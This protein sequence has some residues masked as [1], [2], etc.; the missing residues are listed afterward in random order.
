MSNFVYISLPP[1]EYIEDANSIKDEKNF[2]FAMFNNSLTTAD[3]FLKRKN[4]QPRFLKGFW[5]NK[6]CSKI[7]FYDK[8]NNALLFGTGVDK[9]FSWDKKVQ[10]H[11]M[12]RALLNME[13]A[14]EKLRKGACVIHDD[15]TIH[16][17]SDRTMKE[18]T[19]E[20]TS[21]QTRFTAPY[22]QLSSSEGYPDM[23]PPPGLEYLNP[24][25]WEKTPEKHKQLLADPEK[26]QE[27]HS[28]FLK[29]INLYKA[30]IDD[31]PFIQKVPEEQELLNNSTKIEVEI[32]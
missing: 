11:V 26:V 30:T 23:K 20:Y 25:I 21:L 7:L 13:I 32:L 9:T 1:G 8:Q 24:H 18:Y 28:D 4:Y 29:K 17:E 31:D 14:Y 6:K 15:V 5:L 16:H 22:N 10:P 3:D 27:I 2:D 19:D 12:K